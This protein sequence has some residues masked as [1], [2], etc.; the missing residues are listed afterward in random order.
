[1]E[2]NRYDESLVIEP[3]TRARRSRT[4]APGGRPRWIGLQQHRDDTVAD[5]GA[6]RSPDT[7]D[8]AHADS[9]CA[10]AVT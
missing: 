2:E 4:L 6:H 3:E 7:D 5:D 1:M 10:D 8:G 9:S